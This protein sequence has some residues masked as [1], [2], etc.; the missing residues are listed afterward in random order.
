MDSFI[1]H[2][3]NA[4]PQSLETHKLCILAPTLPPPLSL[5][6]SV[7][8]PMRLCSPPPIPHIVSPNCRN[9]Q[10]NQI[11]LPSLRLQFLRFC[12]ADFPFL[13]LPLAC[14]VRFCRLINIIPRSDGGDA[15]ETCVKKL[16]WAWLWRRFLP[17]VIV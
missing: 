10:T 17:A 16:L 9:S 3:K 6:F 12:T 2:E 14:V 11:H 8:L 1:S 13:E 7:G 15:G 5:L 4:Y